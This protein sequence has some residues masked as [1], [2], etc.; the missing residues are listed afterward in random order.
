MPGGGHE[1]GDGSLVATAIRE[2]REE[3]VVRCA[4]TNI[5][6]ARITTIEHRDEQRS[7]PMLTVTF[8]ARGEGSAS[9]A[10]DEE[11]LEAQWFADPP[12]EF[13]NND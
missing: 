5:R 8:V 1:A 4:V 10:E 6:S 13:G 7:Y 11:V 3:T 12:D 9:A 2:V